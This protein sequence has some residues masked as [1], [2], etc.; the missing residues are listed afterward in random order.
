MEGQLQ[1]GLK[2]KTFILAPEATT[3]LSEASQRSCIAKWAGTG[4]VSRLCDPAF[5]GWFYHGLNLAQEHV[6]KCRQVLFV[7]LY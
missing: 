3:Q 6:F 5:Q 4:S 7:Q 1:Y 2:H